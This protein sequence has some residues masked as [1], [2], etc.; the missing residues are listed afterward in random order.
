MRPQ[1]RS[2]GRARRAPVP[3]LS[4]AA[5]GLAAL[6]A[7]GLMIAQT[8]APRR[9][10]WEGVYTE[11]QAAR[12]MTAY[13][14][15]C[16]GCHA[17]AAEGKAPLVGDPFWKSFSQKTV[18]ELLDF[19]STYMPNG[20]PGSLSKAAYND[21]VAVMLKSNGFPAGN[22]ELEPGAVGDVHIIP[23]DGSTELPA[24]A[25]VR[26][27]GCLARNGTDWVVTNATAPER[28]E[29]VRPP[30]EDAVRPL[31]SRTMPLKFVVTRLDAL[32]GSRVVVNGLLIGAD[33][34]DGLNVT[35][36][37]RVAQTCP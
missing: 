17:L 8:G 15:S 37:S 33:G 14:Q 29:R 30:A 22:R 13:A 1:P 20:N 18:G 6:A 28:A 32:A 4:P 36:V 34:V 31:G 9:T 27:V 11:A 21:I 35:T 23:Q 16:A 10:V 12:G 5:V 2:G 24:N 25:L 3:P 26:V 19:V 7:A